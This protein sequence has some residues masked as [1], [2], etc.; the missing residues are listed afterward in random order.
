[1]VALTACGRTTTVPSPAPPDVVRIHPGTTRYMVVEH[2]HVEQEFRGQPVVTDASTRVALTAALDSAASGLV[3]AIS[4]DSASAAGDAG[5][6]TAAIAG[7]AGARFEAR[8]T[9]GGSV[10]DLTAPADGGPLIDQMALALHDLVPLLPTD[11]AHAAAVWE[12][13]TTVT[14]RTAGIPISLARR[15]TNRAGAWTDHDGEPALLILTVTDYSLTGEGERSG[16]WITMTGTGRSHHHRLVTA[17][18]VVA[19]GI[20]SDTLRADVEISGS[21]LLIPLTQIRTDTVRR[22]N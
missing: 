14:G 6:S 15:S 16:Q 19:L 21:G 5:L 9:A 8:L 22:V 2:R 3:L 7:A 20:R 18:G 1:M 17:G 13:T 4:L 11:G 12:D 10:L